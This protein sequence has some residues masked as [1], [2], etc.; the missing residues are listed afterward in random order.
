MDRRNEKTIKQQERYEKKDPS[1]K[2]Q[3]KT[4]FPA[5]I[6]RMHVIISEAL[7]QALK[8]GKI[9]RNPGK[10]TKPPKARKKEARFLTPEQLTA[11]LESI[12]TDRWYPAFKVDL[13]TGMRLGELCALKWENVDLEKGTVTVKE[14][15]S[16]IKSEHGWVLHFHQ[17]KSNNGL[18]VIPLPTEALGVL[19]KLKARQAAEELR[20]K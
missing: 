14:A 10:A 4:L 2:R 12:S 18:R 1:K 16:R 15:V 5:T 20:L 9:I 7:E 17:P 13:N 19:K 6:R 3:E 8:E 11:F